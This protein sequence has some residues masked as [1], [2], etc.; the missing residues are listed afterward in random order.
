MITINITVAGCRA[1]LEGTPTIVCGNKKKYS[2]KFTFDDEW[3]ANTA[4][5]ARFVWVA[6]G[7]LQHTDVIFTGDTVEIPKLIGTRE[8]LV[9]VFEGDLQTTT[10]ARIYCEPSIL[11]YDGE[12]AEEN[13]GSRPVSS[14]SVLLKDRET[15]TVYELYV[16]GGKM[17]MTAVG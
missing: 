15:G 3:G 17:M 5:T 12:P 7:K 11:C 16:L 14:N 9:G 13:G 2:I 8:V 4:K 6:G 10:P 1:A